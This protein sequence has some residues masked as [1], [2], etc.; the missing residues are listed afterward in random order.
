MAQTSVN[1]INWQ[2]DYSK[3]L[4]K[5]AKENKAVLIF[6]T[7][8]D[9]CG[10]CK[11]LEKELFQS[12]KFKAFSEKNFVLYEANFPMNKDLVTPKQKKKNEELAIKYSQS[13][14]P[15][16]IIVNADEKLLGMKNGS[17]LSEFYYPFFKSALDKK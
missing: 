6:F 17:Y 1:H 14:F 3:S 7:G 16:I 12:E 11:R 9:W 13:S 5:A 15:T 4:A 8:S 2:E 10:P